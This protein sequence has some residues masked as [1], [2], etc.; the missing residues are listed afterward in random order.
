MDLAQRAGVS[1]PSI[2]RIEN[3]EDVSTATLAKVTEALGL[4]LQ[5]RMDG[6]TQ[7]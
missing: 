7:L 6:S 1:R 5:V 4:V 2:A 3:G